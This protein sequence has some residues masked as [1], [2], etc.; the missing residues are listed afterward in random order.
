MTV[1]SGIQD[2]LFHRIRSILPSH[3]SLVDEVSEILDISSDSA[4][5][6]IR[7]EKQLSIDE[8]YLLCKHFYISSDEILS[9]QSDK[10]CFR[11]YLLD[12]KEFRFEQYLE[13]VLRD[14]KSLSEQKNPQ[15]IIVLNELN[16]FQMMQVP[17]VAAFKFFFWSK[18]NLSFS[19]YK[20]QLFTANLPDDKLRKLSMEILNYYVKIPTIELMAQEALSSMMKQICFYHEAGFFKESHETNFL[21]D[22]LVDLMN[23]LRQQA[24]L[25]FKFLHGTDPVGKE[26]NYMLYY[27][28]LILADN[29]ILLISDETRRTY[30]TSNAIN[31]LL[32]DNPVFYERNYQWGKNLIS[33]STLISGSAEKERY[34]FFRGIEDQI[35]K[36]REKV[37][38]N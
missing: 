16:L 36:L 8:F 15:M 28:D 29:T 17:E 18:S 5:R 14:I 34:K 4:Y 37:Y 30:I 38:N 20:D 24:E 2:E 31:L 12:E 25:G 21:C 32:T 9:R 10:I 7:S 22:K 6:R 1:T 26:G 13:A 23:H 3:L 11:S 19:D 27:N 33:K 35:N